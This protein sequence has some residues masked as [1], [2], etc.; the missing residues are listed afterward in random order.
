MYGTEYRI[1]TYV[2]YMSSKKRKA[3][4]IRLQFFA[5]RFYSMFKIKS[6]ETF[7]WAQLWMLKKLQTF[8][9][10]QILVAFR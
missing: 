5:F 1:P 3:V 4:I 6:M 7:L 2:R 9:L 10:V 8:Q